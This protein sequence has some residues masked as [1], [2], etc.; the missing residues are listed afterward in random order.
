[1][2]YPTQRT[3]QQQLQKRKAQRAAQACD[4]CRTLKA[5]CDEGRPGCGSCKEK[6]VDC[7]Y[8][9]PPPKQ[10]DKMTTELVDSIVDL[11]NAMTAK[12]DA[13][14]A[15]INALKSAQL[16]PA[17]KRQS[18]EPGFK[19]EI[20]DS[21]QQTMA[22][23]SRPSVGSETRTFRSADSPYSSHSGQRIMERTDQPEQYS[24][25]SVQQS[26]VPEKPRI[27][28]MMRRPDGHAQPAHPMASQAPEEEEEMGA[29]NP[30]PAGVSTMPVNHTTGAA[31][32]LLVPPIA[33]LCRDIPWLDKKGSDMF[34]IVTENRRGCLRLFGNGEGHDAIPG[35]DKDPITDHVPNQSPGDSPMNAP[36]PDVY[37]FNDEWGQVGGFTPPASTDYPHR[38]ITRGDINSYGLP[39]LSRSTV[40]TW[41]NAYKKNIN[42]MHPI[43]APKHLDSLV[44]TFLKNIPELQGRP[45]QVTSLSAG[46][47]GGGGYTNPESPSAKR[48]RSPAS[49]EYT[50]ILGMPEHKPGHPSRDMTTCI[51]LLCMALGK[52]SQCSEKICDYDVDPDK[53]SDGSWGSSP[54]YRNGYPPS[55]IHGSSAMATPNAMGSPQ[56][57]DRNRSRSRRTSI[58]NG[59]LPRTS[60]TKAR[61]IDR[62][63]GLSYYAFATDI[64]GNQL[65][66]NGLQHVHA[67]ILASLYQGQIARVME[68]H[69]YISAA[70]R[71][72]QVML[73]VKI[74]RFKQLKL[75]M[76]PPLPKDNPLV[77][78]FWTC[79]QL[80]SDILAELPCPHSGILTFEED[81]PHPNVGAAHADGFDKIVV[82]SYTAQ[83]C[84]RKHLNSLHSTFYKPD[85]DLTPVS[86]FL[87]IAASIANL[88]ESIEHWA[89]SMPWDTDRGEPATNILEARLRAKYY[90]AQVITY[91]H[92]ILKILQGSASA[93]HPRDD[94][95]SQLPVPEIAADDSTVREYASKGIRALIHSTRAFHNIGPPWEKRLIVTNVWGTAHAQWGNMLV[96]QASYMNPI[97]KPLLLQHISYEDLRM[98]FNHTIR[99]LKLVA[100]PSSALTSDWKILV[101][102]GCKSGLWPVPPE[103]SSSFGSTADTPM[104]GH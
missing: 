41:I 27:P 53:D 78:A 48:K 69:A 36:S 74:D 68:S 29:G 19:Q 91:R 92:F 50:E 23:Y 20:E 38:E 42:N 32:L 70:C 104:V 88:E 63:P 55:P 73:R 77:F 11:K 28:E 35:Y 13:L 4:S 47:V 90:G 22:V 45:K 97:L 64:I 59:S 94:P 26:R 18:V 82:E 25:N 10:Q 100:S 101:H 54:I 66:G 71:S 58:E 95:S 56:D 16:A 37:T 99:F 44:E 2:T 81:M 1:M 34:P 85:S 12:F 102:T 40:W 15:E 60:S 21:N 93:R 30:G 49:G 51:V 57:M 5:K 76:E 31:K 80:E 96:L 61:N 9:D 75:D 6:G 46:F 83:L 103:A 7:H 87:S 39:D 98:L 84:L 86:F 67:C 65:A 52:I 3:E 43:L 79:L 62:V 33:E 89:P 72:L 24:S 8:R 17:S 14:Q